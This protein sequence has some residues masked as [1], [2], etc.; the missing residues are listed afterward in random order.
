MYKKYLPI[1]LMGLVVFIF[2]WKFFFKGLLPIPAD[3]IIGLYHPYRDLYSKNYPNGIPFKNF[4]ITDPVRQQYPWKKLSVESLQKNQIPTWNPYSFSG[5]PLL[6]NFQT[7][8]FYPVNILFFIFPFNISWTFFIVLQPFLAGIFLYLYLKNLKLDSVS[9]FFGSIVFSFSGFFTS[10]L[11]WGN[12]L[13]S[14]LWLPLILLSIDKVIFS[15]NKIIWNIIFIFSLCAS[16]L[17]GHLQTFFYIFLIALFYSLIKIWRSKN[18][19]SFILLLSGVSISIFLTAIQWIPTAR[20][21]ILSARDS[22]RILWEN[23]GWFMPLAHLIQILVPDFFGNPTTLNYWGVWNY[24]ELTAY[25]G[26]TALIL[27]IFAVIFRRDRKSYFFGFLVFISLIFATENPISRIP[28]ILNVPFISTAQPTRL[29]FVFNFAV[30]VLSALGISKI[31]E[32]GKNM[33]ITFSIILVGLTYLVLFLVVVFGVNIGIKP[34]N[35]DIAKRNLIFPILIFVS[36]S[37]LMLI[38]SKFSLRYK[39]FILVGLI[40]LTVFDLFRFSWKFNT[41][42]KPD[43]LYPETQT[44][45]YLEENIGNYRIATNDPRIMAPNFSNIYKIQTVEGYDPLFTS[46]YAELISAIN[47]NKP[48]I[49]PPF[50]FNRIV[51]LDNLN[52]KFSDLL[53]V[54]YVLSLN[55]IDDPKYK[56]VFEEGLT[57]TYE[58]TNVLP[59]AFFVKKVI[60]S[61]DKKDSISLMFDSKYKPGESAIVEGYKDIENNYSIGEARIVS[62]SENKVVIN[63]KIDSDGLGFLILTDS[64]YPT[65]HAK[66][67]G[68]SSN[69]VIYRTD[70]NFR[71]IVVPGGNHV[72]TFYNELL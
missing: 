9:S 35:L 58:N 21:I 51:R 27:A 30:S 22:D 59:K 17:A 3:T 56:K 60:Y 61:K 10:W 72:I 67:E 55:E 28:Y 52:S 29:I 46:R 19:K 44:I 48:D 6:A 42:S 43:Y 4:L 24:G 50:G 16:L 1:L 5:T 47:R 40:A 37:F 64:F 65:W 63:T 25:F 31:L 2:F 49:N 45:R 8:V 71:G 66:I 36:S 41:F 38:L 14:A 32:K 54:K 62:Y 13:H 57:K 69:P 53:G 12:I 33:Q 34:D 70:Y 68:Y 11:E 39:N 7:G 23:E 20:F 15:K 18:I 26:I